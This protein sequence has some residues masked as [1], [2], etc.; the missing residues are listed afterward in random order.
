VR[1]MGD[2]VLLD[3]SHPA[4]SRGRYDIISAAPD[5]VVRLGDAGLELIE[6]GTTTNPRESSPFALLESL[7]A[8]LGQYETDADI[9]FNGG[10]MG[11]FS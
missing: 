3:S 11:I 10:F 2:P 4:S 5:I 9:P 7:L 1:D 8:D 6:N